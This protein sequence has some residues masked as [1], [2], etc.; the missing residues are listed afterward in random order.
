M[1]SES[2][3][4]LTPE[5]YLERE[6][7]AE[8]RSEYWQGEMF[9]TAGGSCYHARIIRNLLRVLGNELLSTD[10]Q[11]YGV[12]LRLH[13]PA[14]GLYTYPDAT[15]TCGEEQYLDQNF[16]T[17][18]NPVLLA[19][20]LSPSTRNY[21]LGGKFEAYRS[22]PSLREYLTIDS[23]RIQVI[24]HWLSGGEWH[25]RDYRDPLAE[26]QLRSLPAVVLRMSDLYDK[27]NWPMAE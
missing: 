10:C 16:D 15:V 26:I 12:E 17:L 20:V 4:Y 24:Q 13:I 6:R 25:L 5:Q 27:V 11:P 23:E 2:K 18:L 3:A 21:D 22:I 9:A 14:T 8:F 7:V 1:A 19:E